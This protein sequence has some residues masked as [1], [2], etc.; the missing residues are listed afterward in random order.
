MCD[1][2]TSASV[3]T[4]IRWW[5]SFS[6]SN[7]SP[8]LVPIAVMID[9]ISAFER[10]LLMRFFS[11]LMTL[12]RSGRMAWKWRGA[13]R[14]ADRSAAGRVP[15]GEV[16]L[17]VGRIAGL[18]VGQL[19]REGGAVERAFAPRQL[20]RLAGG[21]ARVSRRDR[22]RDHLPPVGRVLLEEL[23]KLGVH[24]LL[25][26]TAYP[27]VPELRL[28]LPLELW[29]A[30]LDRDDGSETFAHVLSLEVLV[31]VLQK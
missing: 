1:P 27:R 26:E 5:R 8:M 11:E 21:L 6:R 20:P 19:A 10:T 7:S 16:K 25:D 30:Q 13:G 4:M 12:P 31:L 28:R 14:A 17:G 22:L 15:L 18:A 9:W 3:M 24:G 2:S 29:I 23:G